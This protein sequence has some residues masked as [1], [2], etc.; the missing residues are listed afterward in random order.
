MINR[1]VLRSGSCA[2]P[3]DHIRISCRHFLP[4]DA[5]WQLCG[6]RLAR[7]LD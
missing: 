5:L 2:T 3:L 4:A 7:D 1:Y 6:V